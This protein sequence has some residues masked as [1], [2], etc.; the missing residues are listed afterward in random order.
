VNHDVP[1]LVGNRTD[2]GPVREQNEDYL[3]YFRSG[4]RHVFMVADGMGG[5]AGGALASR[6]AVEAAGEVFSSDPCRSPRDLLN[7]A[8][9]AANRACRELR[10]TR[11]ELDRLG[12]TLDLVL[13]EGGRAWWAHVGDGRIYLLRDREIR[14]L[15]DDHTLVE[16]MVREGLLSEDEAAGHP[17][18]HVLERALGP[19]NQ[20]A[21]DLAP[22]PLVLDDGD[23]LILC[24]DGLTDVVAPEE[25]AEAIGRGGPQ[26]ACR[27]LVEL[28]RERGGSDNVTV[29]VIHRGAA[30]SAWRSR[31]TGNRR[32]RGMRRLI[33]VGVA[34][35]LGLAI[36]TVLIFLS[37]LPVSTTTE[38]SPVSSGR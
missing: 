2:A 15:T 21:P 7:G 3:G 6:G 37:P 19:S 32:A 25:I 31:P 11:P 4:D 24:T 1:L 10:E 23:S 35:L 34:L 18:R 9:A 36:A 20:V 17:R 13:V 5:E 30:P 22:E 38:S 14:Q 8:M 27:Q 33:F 29:Q 16:R 28:V 26:Q 12:T